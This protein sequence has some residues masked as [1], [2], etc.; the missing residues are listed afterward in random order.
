LE[1][2]APPP[3]TVAPA[4]TATIPSMARVGA[5]RVPV[6]CSE[7]CD[8]RVRIITNEEFPFP[9][10]EAVRAVAS[11][12]TITVRPLKFVLDA[13]RRDPPPS[14]RIEVMASDRAGNVAQVAGTVALRR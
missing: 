13:W 4:L 14:L 12:A 10:A 7:P 8:V 11:S 9:D 6:T 5:L 1:R 3:D 2:D